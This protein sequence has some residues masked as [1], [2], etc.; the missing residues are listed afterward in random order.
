MRDTKVTGCSP[1]GE[2]HSLNSSQKNKGSARAVNKPIFVLCGKVNPWENS[3]RFCQLSDIWANHWGVN[4]ILINTEHRHCWP[5][6]Q[7]EQMHQYKEPERLRLWW[8]ASSGCGDRH[9]GEVFRGWSGRGH[10]Q[11]PH[12]GGAGLVDECLCREGSFRAPGRV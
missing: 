4:P 5:S 2:A 1:Q 9:V 7:Q 11:I 3:R 8:G 6:E 10:R 12:R